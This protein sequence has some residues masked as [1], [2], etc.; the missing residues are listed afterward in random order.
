M[1]VNREYGSGRRT[2][3]NRCALASRL[4]WRLKFMRRRGLSPAFAV[5]SS[6]RSLSINMLLILNIPHANDSIFS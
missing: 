2:L 4:S 1:T 5:T 3:I 6:R